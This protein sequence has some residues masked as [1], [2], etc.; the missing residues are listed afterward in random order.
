MKHYL[1]INAQ[2]FQKFMHKN[3]KNNEQRIT[4][5]QDSK[6]IKTNVVTDPTF[7]RQTAFQPNLI[8]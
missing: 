6:R 4:H 8:M 3:N 5:E 1:K 2:N 7:L